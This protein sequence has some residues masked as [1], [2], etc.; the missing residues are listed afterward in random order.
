[1]LKRLMR[2]G[3]ALALIGAPLALGAQTA[4][5]PQPQAQPQ[6]PA[7]PAAPA[8]PAVVPVQARPALWVVRDADTTI[9]L[10]GTVHVLRPGIQWFEGPV[11]RAFD[12]SGEL[13]LELVQPPA[14]EM[15]QIALGLGMSQTG[16]ALSEKLS[17]ERRALLASTAN[18]LGL[19]MAV[20]DRMD[21]WF[22]ALNLGVITMLRAG[23]DP[24]SGVEHQL[25]QAATAANKPIVGLE[26][27]AQQLGYFDTLP[28]P[29]QLRYLGTTLDQLPRANTMLDGMIASWS[30]GQPDA[31]ARTMNEAMVDTPEVARVLLADRNTRWA[32]WIR[33]RMARPG[34]VFVAVGAGHLAGDASVQAALARLNLRAE[35]VQ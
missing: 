29:V 7:A 26:T 30:A 14:A 21:P 16:P 17:P 32:A 13:V 4:P 25:T 6:P 22:A 15:Q 23:F 20:V 27:A 33:D 35:R 11:R 18:G 19:P 9:Y 24:A 31:L 34:T 3:T 5:Q 12:A 8:A 10:M 2:A 1:M 28:E